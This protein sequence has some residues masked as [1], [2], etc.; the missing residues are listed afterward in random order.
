MTNCPICGNPAEEAVIVH[1]LFEKQS[2]TMTTYH[3]R[4]MSY[5][6][7][8]MFG[9]YASLFAIWQFTA[10]GMTPNQK[11]LSAIFMLSSIALFVL[12]EV[13]KA[14]HQSNVMRLYRKSFAKPETRSSLPK[15]L[16]TTNHYES[17]ALKRGLVADRVWSVLFP[18]T[19]VTGVIAAAILIWAFISGL[20]A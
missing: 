11:R 16:E 18:L 15:L 12:F 6:T 5:T 13:Y 20:A 7:L 14:F 1:K 19:A 17:E 3:E 10:D 2:A 4:T 9:G 8:V